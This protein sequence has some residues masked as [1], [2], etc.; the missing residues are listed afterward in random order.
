M[1]D[2]S[3]RHDYP[4]LKDQIQLTWDRLDF[5]ADR[6]RSELV[7]FLLVTNA[8]GAIAA[9]GFMGAS[10]Q[11]RTMIS[12][13]LALGCYLLGLIFTGLMHWHVFYTSYNNHG[14][15]HENTNKHY[16]GEMSPEELAKL[17]QDPVKEQRL[18]NAFSIAAFSM[19]VLGSGFGLYGLL[20]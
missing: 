2:S 5:E 14:K 16:R 9:I 12:P 3:N 18:P 4:T 10:D 11:V 13:K 8:G 19:F 7:R 20:F 1:T 17:T 6:A 15:F